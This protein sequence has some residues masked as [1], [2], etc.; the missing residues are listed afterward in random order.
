[1]ASKKG[2]SVCG[3]IG[4]NIIGIPGNTF[5]SGVIAL[6]VIVCCFEGSVLTL[7]LYTVECLAAIQKIKYTFS[8]TGKN[9]LIIK[10]ALD[11][12]NIIPNSFQTKLGFLNH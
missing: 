7:I 6:L 12:Y 10:G 3:E 11:K 5:S 1:M 9:I 8:R 2:Q 4:L